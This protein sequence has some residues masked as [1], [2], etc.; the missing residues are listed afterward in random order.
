MLDTIL[1]AM[2]EGL[3]ELVCHPGYNDRDLDA[4]TTRLRVTREI[5]R[6][7]LLGALGSNSLHPN[8]PELIHYGSLGRMGLLRQLGQHAPATGHENLLR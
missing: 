4:F 8:S 7:A 2:P 5:E 3:W 1:A 6:N